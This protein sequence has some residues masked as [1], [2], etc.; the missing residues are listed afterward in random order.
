[1]K[2]APS[3]RCLKESATSPKRGSERARSGSS[4]WSRREARA[5][6]VRGLMSVVHSSAR[7]ESTVTTPISITRSRAGSRPVVSVSTNASRF[8]ASTILGIYT[9]T[10]SLASAQPRSR[11]RALS[12]RRVSDIRQRRP[13]ADRRGAY[14]SR[15]GRFANCGEAQS[16]RRTGSRNAARPVSPL[17]TTGDRNEISYHG[18]S[19]HDGSLRIAAAAVC[20]RR[21]RSGDLQGDPGAAPRQASPEV[22]R[23][24][25]PARRRAEDA[26]GVARRG[27]EVERRQA[28]Q[29]CGTGL[30]PR[31]LL[32]FAFAEGREAVGPHDE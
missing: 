27:G 6:V 32:A 5:R 16:F 4:S 8:A 22:R 15:R 11:S 29:Q 25:Q 17:S 30:E 9:A 28:L 23:D 18:T 20:L 13:T 1:M 24:D 14:R 21:A 19:G 10:A 2:S 3:R 26:G 31:L 7:P 12:R